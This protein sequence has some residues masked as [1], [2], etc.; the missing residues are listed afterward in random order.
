MNVWQGI[1]SYDDRLYSIKSSSAVVEVYDIEE[2]QGFQVTIGNLKLPYDIAAND[3]FVF[4]SEQESRGVIFTIEL[5]T[6]VVEPLWFVDPES[7]MEIPFKPYDMSKLSI[8]KKGNLVMAVKS[9]NSI[10]EVTETI[11]RVHSVKLP[12]MNVGG[13]DLTFW[14]LE[15]AIRLDDDRYVICHYNE[16]IHRVSIIDNQGAVLNSY[17][18]SPGGDLD[19]FNEPVYMATDGE[20]FIFV[21][22]RKNN[23][24][25]KLDSRLEFVKKY[26][27]KSPH[28]IALL[29]DEHGCQCMCSLSPGLEKYRRTALETRLGCMD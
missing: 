20:G 14:G 18:G 19:Q 12:A 28:K 22:D 27:V 4:V 8:T 5:S 25:V 13:I 7:E 11:R 23:R 6:R 15:H 9:T 26:D 24:V 10:F 2:K 17:G 21:A 16:S 29:E 3:K 1:S